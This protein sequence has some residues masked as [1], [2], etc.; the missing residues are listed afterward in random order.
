MYGTYIL[1]CMVIIGIN[2]HSTCSSFAGKHYFFYILQFCYP[3]I[4]IIIICIHIELLA[5]S[6]SLFFKQQNSNEKNNDR[7]TL[8]FHVFSS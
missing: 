1:L 3:F 8:I 7:S 2:A 6:N 4:I 5:D